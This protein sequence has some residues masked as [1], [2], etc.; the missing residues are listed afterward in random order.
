MWAA[1]EKYILSSEARCCG[2]V[3]RAD[4][5]TAPSPLSLPEPRLNVLVCEQRV[6]ICLPRG[7]VRERP[8]QSS[9]RHIWSSR[10]GAEEVPV[11]PLMVSSVCI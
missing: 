10:L 11:V 2:L 3:P 9:L 7:Y 1:G 6:S 4:L 8:C 5:A